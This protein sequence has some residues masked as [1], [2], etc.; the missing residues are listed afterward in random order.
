MENLA[1]ASAAALVVEVSA[2]AAL[3]KVVRVKTAER[4]SCFRRHLC[5]QI[6]IAPVRLKVRVDAESSPRKD[7]F[8]A[9]G[10]KAV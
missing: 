2:R 10:D 8:S 5:S 6:Q 3:A 7:V 4:S 9:A 1:R